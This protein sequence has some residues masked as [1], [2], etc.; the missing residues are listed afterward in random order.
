[1]SASCTRRCWTRSSSGPSAS[2]SARSPIAGLAGGRLADPRAG[3]PSRHPDV[4]RDLAVVVADARPAAEVAAAITRHGGPL[5]R[6][7][8]LFDS[9]RGR[10]LA[11][12]E[13]SLAFRLVF[14][15]DDRTLTEAEVAEAVEA[16]TA[17]PC[18]RRRRDVSGPDPHADARLQRTGPLRTRQNAHRSRL[19]VL[20]W[21][22]TRCYPCAALPPA[23]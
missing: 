14:A 5:L 16:V 8:D 21:P 1:M 13:R 11:D 7:V 22:D 17:G 3:T 15:G 19:R 2:S 6:S 9:Y 20:R 4:E 12:D 10:P 18:G 23:G